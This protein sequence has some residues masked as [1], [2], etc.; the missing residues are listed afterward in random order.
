MEKIFYKKGWQKIGNN[1]FVY[2]Q[3]DGSWGLNNAGMIIDDDDALLIDTLYDIDHTRQML[4]EMKTFQPGFTHPTMVV[5][6]HADGDHF[7]GNICVKNAD[8]Y[9][10]ETCIEEMKNLPPKKMNTLMTLWF[11]LGPAGSYAKNAFREFS[12]KNIPM[13]LP[14]HSFNDKL[15][16]DVGKK[17]VELIEI[18]NTHKEG[19][20]IV[21]IPGD[22]VVF[23]ADILF[24]NAFPLAWAG[25]LQN[26]IDA[27]DFILSLDVTTIVPGHG[28]VVGKDEVKDVKT[29]FLYIYEQAKSRLYKGLSIM[30][31]AASID[32]GGYAEWSE[33]ERIVSM[34]EC[35]S[36]E[37]NPSQK[38][39]SPVKLFGM[40]AKLKKKMQ[41]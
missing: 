40:M 8:I 10:S 31:T 16:L 5:N 30:E 12:Y 2:L 38:K 19:N 25:P 32:I 17:K 7:Y 39:L 18:K 33:K 15:T 1:I 11:L 6:T 14:N 27:L 22:K 36:R 20:I 21:H 3:P 41:W 34:V 23:T 13:V 28:P 37:L 9:S 35:V 29:F 24:I 26:W 4:N